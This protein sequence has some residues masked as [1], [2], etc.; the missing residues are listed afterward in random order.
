MHSEE[1]RPVVAELHRADTARFHLNHAELRSQEWKA[2]FNELF[3]GHVPE[4]TG[5]FMPVQIDFPKHR[6]G[7]G[8]GDLFI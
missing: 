1:Y 5:I 2:A 4:G 7:N 8:V 6:S 3:D